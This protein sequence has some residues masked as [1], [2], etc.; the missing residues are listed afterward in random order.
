MRF[1]NAFFLHNF[2]ARSVAAVAIACTALLGASS[3]M[4]QGLPPL[5]K[6]LNPAQTALI[7][8]DFQYPFTNLDG[9]NHRAVKKELEEKHLLDRTVDLVKK[10]RSSGVLVVHITEGY[11]SDYREVDATNPGGF[12]R[13][14]ILRQAWKVGTTETSYYPPLMPGE[15]DKDLFPAPRNQISAF[16]GTGLNEILRSK[17]S[18]T[19]R[20]A[21]LRPTCAST[22]RSPPHSTWATT[23]MRCA[24]PWPDIS[25]SSPR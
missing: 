3:A 2:T 19:S 22:P 17:G 8:I 9:A 7:L 23:S 18:R 5:A 6:E 16:G 13:G 12:H 10:A 21:A 25:R 11:T 15:G 20:S 24:T 14:Q 1:I 4:A